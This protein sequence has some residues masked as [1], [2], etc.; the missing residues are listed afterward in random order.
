MRYKNCF[1]DPKTFIRLLL[2]FS[3]MYISNLLVDCLLVTA[4]S[5]YSS[6]LLLNWLLLTAVCMEAIG[7]ARVEWMSSSDIQAS[8]EE[9]F[10]YTTVLPI[11]GKPPK[12]L[13][14]PTPTLW[15]SFLLSCPPPNLAPQSC[16]LNIVPSTPNLHPCLLNPNLST[17]LCHCLPSHFPSLMSKLKVPFY[18]MVPLFI[19][20]DHVTPYLFE[21]TTCN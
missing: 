13:S 18:C 6:N 12:P 2:T 19:S 5:M 21:H 7:E 17:S 11:K 4:H 15:P 8:D 9:V 16:L 20:Y 3:F 1:I 14:P 10:N